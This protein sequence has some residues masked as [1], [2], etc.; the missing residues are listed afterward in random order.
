VELRDPKVQKVIM[1]YLGV[2][3][4]AYMVFL[5]SL[6]PFSYKS[7]ARE[8][9]AL[10]SEIEQLDSQVRIARESLKQKGRLEELLRASREKALEARE[11][12]PERNDSSELLRKLVV[13]A[14]EAG[15]RVTLF[16]P[17]RGVLKDGYV[18]FPLELTVQG[19]YHGVGLLLAK[20]SNCKRI[21][22]VNSLSLAALPDQEQEET[23]EAT[24]SLVTYAERGGSDETDSSSG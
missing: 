10:K 13:L 12:L 23:L 20:I 15:V 24:L 11:L 18:E 1:L 9:A 16:K 19:N 14:Q 2:G 3:A 4:V 5:N 7:R 8:I 6:L 17:A 21:V 22:R